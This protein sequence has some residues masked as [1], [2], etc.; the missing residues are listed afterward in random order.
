MQKNFKFREKSGIFVSFLSYSHH[1]DENNQYCHE[2]LCFG[3]KKVI[4][5]CADLADRPQKDSNVIF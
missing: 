4:F 2:S 5:M 3:C 1:I